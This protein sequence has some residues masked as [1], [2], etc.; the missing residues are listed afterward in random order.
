MLGPSLSKNS[1]RVSGNSRVLYFFFDLA[2]YL[3][4]SIHIFVATVQLKITFG[5]TDTS[6]FFIQLGNDDNNKNNIMQ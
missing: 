4:H 3:A 6:V 1:W 5:F 2:G